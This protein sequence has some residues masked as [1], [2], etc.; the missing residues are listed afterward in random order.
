MTMDIVVR[1]VGSALVIV[2][3]TTMAQRNAALG[4]WLASLPLVTVL[5]IAWLSVDQRGN[6]QIVRFLTG[7]LWGL[8][9]TAGLLVITAGLLLRGSIYQ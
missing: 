8:A 5:S 2:A 9:P 3:I 6:G 1:A 4:G 7:V